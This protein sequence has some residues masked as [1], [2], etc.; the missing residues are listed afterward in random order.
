MDSYISGLKSCLDE[1]SAQKQTMHDIADMIKEAHERGSRIFI[2]GNGGSAT[3]ASH[4]ARDLK[5]GTQGKNKVLAECLTDNMAVVTSIANDVN[6]ASIFAEQ[7][8]GQAAQDDIVIGISCSGT[9]VNVYNG[10]VWARNQLAKTVGILGF[11]GGTIINK[12]DKS[13]VFSSKDYGQCEDVHAV[14]CHILTNLVKR[15]IKNE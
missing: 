14:V 10:L 9:S 4:F 8:F 15:R 12:C 13:I 5:I 6:Y 2:M 7:M 11:G 3:T 1:L